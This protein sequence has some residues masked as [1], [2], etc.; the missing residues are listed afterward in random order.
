MATTLIGVDPS[1]PQTSLPQL[2]FPW[3]IFDMDGTLV[4]TFQLNRRSFNYAVRKFLKRT[5]T[6]EEAL[7]ITGGT[8]EEQ[9]TNYM[10]VSGVPGAIQRHYAHYARHFDGTRVFPG[11]RGLLFTLHAKGV[12]LAVCTGADGRIAE[13]TLARSG[14]SK[15]FTTVVT[16]DDV[17]KPKPDPEGLR[18]VMERIGADS[19]QTAYVG[20]HPNDIGASRSAGVKTAGARWGSKHKGELQALKPDFLFNHPSEALT[21]SGFRTSIS[22]SPRLYARV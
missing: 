19:D 2:A 18:I 8:L 16:A 17:S 13:Y 11:V 5:L 1:T 9:L 14:L 20:D 6:T 12:E 3:V 15:F 4:D 21:L 10:P 22:T 7:G